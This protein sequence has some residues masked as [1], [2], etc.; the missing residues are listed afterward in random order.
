MAEAELIISPE[1]NKKAMKDAIKKLDASIDKSAKQSGKEFEKN[2]STGL[3]KAGKKGGLQLF[4]T[5]KKGMA[6]LAVAIAG[7]VTAGLS[8]AGDRATNAEGAFSGILGD[9]DARDTVNF[10]KMQGMSLSRAASF[11]RKVFDAGGDDQ[12]MR[13]FLVDTSEFVAQAKAGENQ[14]LKNFVNVKGG[15][16]SQF[17]AVLASLAS[18]KPEE[19]NKFLADIGWAG[20]SAVIAGMLTGLKGKT[21]K[22]AFAYLETQTA[23]D[24]KRGALID[25]EANLETRFINLNRQLN[26]SAKEDYLNAMTGDTLKAYAKGKLQKQK[27]TMNDIINYSD[28]ETKA[29]K[30]EEIKRLGANQILEVTNV[31]IKTIIP[32]FVKLQSW[33][34]H[35]IVPFF[36]KIIKWYASILRPIFNSSEENKNYDERT[37]NAINHHLNESSYKA[38]TQKITVN[39]KKRKV[40]Y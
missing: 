23:E 17:N 35:V 2:I 11:K 34:N 16:D 1:I 25:K 13:D 24:K 14:L 27:Q 10:S 29:Q 32:F 3:E 38:T 30:L 37:E 28:N 15:A 7:L 9:G 19:V 8:I 31:I 39:G 4:S 40:G 20:D 36:D 5:L 18:K 6:G 21:D 22:Q 33:F 12:M 26:V